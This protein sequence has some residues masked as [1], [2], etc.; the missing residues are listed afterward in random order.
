MKYHEMP[1]SARDFEVHEPGQRGRLPAQE[2]DPAGLGEGQSGLDCP[3]VKTY[4]LQDLPVGFVLRIQEGGFG[5]EPRAPAQWE[6]AA[7]IG[8][9]NFVQPSFQLLDRR[10]Q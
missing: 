7:A 8:A 2:N 10:L 6:D 1:Q 4:L 9:A 3:R 5:K